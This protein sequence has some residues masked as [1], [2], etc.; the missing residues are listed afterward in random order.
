MGEKDILINFDKEEVK[1]NEEING[2][3][4]INY[5]GRFDSV[6]INSQIDNTSEIFNFVK[7]YDKKINYS[8]ARMP[9]LKPDLKDENEIKFTAITKHVP[10]GSSKVKFRAAII[11]EHKEVADDVAFIKIVQ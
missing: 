8:Y 5:Q 4:K 1:A 6:V 9:I 2:V 11:Q 3:I 10:Q 7:L